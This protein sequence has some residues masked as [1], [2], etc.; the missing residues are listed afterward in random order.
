[1][2]GVWASA[3]ARSV[4][5][6]Y[7]AAP[8]RLRAPGRVHLRPA[9]RAG[10]PA[11][12]RPPHARLTLRVVHQLGREDRTHTVLARTHTLVRRVERHLAAT[13]DV[14]ERRHRVEQVALQPGA[15]P[16]LAPDPRGGAAARAPAPLVVP[17]L[18]RVLRR[19][20]APEPA[21][22]PP[23][24]AGPPPVWQRAQ[25]AP[26]AIDV[27]RLTD[28]VMRGIDRRLAAWRERRGRV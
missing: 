7:S 3:F 25:G 10:A 28:E 24:V 22:D 16:R 27:A 8:G 17:P 11:R 2:I 18:P 21:A 15:M 19:A 9:R 6:R 14:V 26:P 1:V 23:R 20:V 13:R 12:G 5:A 4:A